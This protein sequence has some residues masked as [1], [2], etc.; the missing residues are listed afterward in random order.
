MRSSTAIRCSWIQLHETQWVFRLPLHP[1]YDFWVVPGVGS[2]LAAGYLR[3]IVGGVVRGEEIGEP[4]SV[5]VAFG[6]VVEGR[7]ELLG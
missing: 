1:R 4:E 7:D 5:G 3:Q 6:V 2:R